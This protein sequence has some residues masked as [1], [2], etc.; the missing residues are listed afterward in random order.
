M[1]SGR[2]N[3]LAGIILMVILLGSS[4]AISQAQSP[5][6]LR[7]YS[8][9]YTCLQGLTRLTLRVFRPN[10]ASDPNVIFAFGPDGRHSCRCGP[11]LDADWDIAGLGLHWNSEVSARGRVRCAF[12]HV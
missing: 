7:E 10:S 4:C 1:T 12:S 11:H 8:G 5:P 9:S 3:G 2:A 6:V